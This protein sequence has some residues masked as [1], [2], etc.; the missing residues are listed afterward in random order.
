MAYDHLREKLEDELE[1]L[2]KKIA[3]GH[4]LDKSEYECAKTW[5]KTIVAMQT[6]EAMD[7]EY[8]GEGDYEAAYAR[9]PRRD[10]MGRYSR[11]GGR[12]EYR[13][14]MYGG[15]VYRGGRGGSRGGGRYSYHGDDDPMNRLQEAYENADSEQERKTI[16]K[17]MEQM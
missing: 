9:G 13:R 16:R 17:L 14:S 4:D 1:A 10:G 15:P 7:E 8:E 2:D 3:Q 5:V 12:T 6:M 11:D